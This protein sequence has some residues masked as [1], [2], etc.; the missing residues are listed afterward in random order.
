[1]IREI[2]R[3]GIN[4]VNLPLLWKTKGIRLERISD[5]NDRATWQEVIDDKIRLAIGK[6][7]PKRFFSDNGYFT[8]DDQIRNG[9]RWTIIV[10]D[11]EP[12]FKGEVFRQ[13]VLLGGDN[14]IHYLEYNDPETEDQLL[15]YPNQRPEGYWP[16]WHYSSLERLKVGSFYDYLEEAELFDPTISP[17]SLFKRLSTMGTPSPVSVEGWKG[18]LIDSKAILDCLPQSEI[19]G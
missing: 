5:L 3:Y 12:T 11:F 6:Q 13:A 2:F 18:K 19:E 9:E 10:R 4:V 16:N 17:K 8:I 14:K 7:Y 1:M 15:D